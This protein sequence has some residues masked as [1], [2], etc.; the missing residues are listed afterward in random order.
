MKNIFFWIEIFL[1]FGGIVLCAAG[2]LWN[3]I[4]EL[5]AFFGTEAYPDIGFKVAMSGFGMLVVGV[6]LLYFSR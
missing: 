5:L 3:K 6:G 1:V 4:G 2:L